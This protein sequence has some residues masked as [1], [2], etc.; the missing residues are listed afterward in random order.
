MWHI[1]RLWRDCFG[2]IS[3]LAVQEG[4]FMGNLVSWHRFRPH[5]MSVKTGLPL[6]LSDVGAGLD[7]VIFGPTF[8]TVANTPHF[9]GLKTSFILRDKP[10]DNPPDNHSLFIIFGKILKRVIL[11]KIKNYN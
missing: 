9:A 11:L 8:R 4:Y 3:E 6:P 2:V 7:E 10:R 5:K 1:I